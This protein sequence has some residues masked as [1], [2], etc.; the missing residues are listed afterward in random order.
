M[1]VTVKKSLHVTSR[2]AWRAWL[3]R[4][5]RRKTEVWLVFFKAHTGKPRVE[6]DDA[7]EEALCFGWVD[8]LVKRLD[9]ERYA[10]KFTPRK[11]G[12]RWSPSNRT[13]VAKLVREGR[14]TPAGL[15]VTTFRVA[16]CSG[17]EP[18]RPR[19]PGQSRSCLPTSCGH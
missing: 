2:A 14:M 4:N 13:R 18:P 3:E 10:Q 5:H 17:Q 12:S 8:S 19:G 7:V 6:Y 1:S 15:A 9:E 16:D 11:A